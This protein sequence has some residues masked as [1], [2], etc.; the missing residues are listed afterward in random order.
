MSACRAIRRLSEVAVHRDKG[1]F[2]GAQLTRPPCQSRALSRRSAN[3]GNG[4][5]ADV[6]RS[7]AMHPVRT[8]DGRYIV[9]IGRQG[10]RLWRAANPRLSPEELQKLTNQLMTARRTVKA[11]QGNPAAVAAARAD[12]DAAKRALGERGVVWWDDGT[13][14]LSRVL[15]RN[16]PYAAWWE[17]N[18]PW[19]ILRRVS[20]GR[21]GRPEGGQ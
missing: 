14:D 9:H 10:P 7:S 8:P 6:R 16:S 3:V 2:S 11:A 18:Q 13:P 19:P 1:Q 21:S 5:K 15:V 20:G 4:S 17:R 12:V